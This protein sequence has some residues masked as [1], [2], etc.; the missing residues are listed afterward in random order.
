MSS[1]GPYTAGGDTE[2]GESAPVPVRYSDSVMSSPG[3]SSR[4]RHQFLTSVE[5]VSPA[6][7]QKE[8]DAYLDPDPHYMACGSKILAPFV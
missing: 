2:G 3:P 1:P 8:F 6:P 5:T 4:R 7:V